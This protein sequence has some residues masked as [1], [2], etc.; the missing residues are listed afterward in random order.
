MEKYLQI[1]ISHGA[2]SRS[3]MNLDRNPMTLI[4][5]MNSSVVDWDK[6]FK[7]IIVMIME[8]GYI[9]LIKL[10]PDTAWICTEP[11]SDL[12]PN[13]HVCIHRIKEKF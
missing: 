12:P 5:A 7:S 6:I 1:H 11:P 2:W 10:G 9:Q 3:M 4:Y 13:M 8:K